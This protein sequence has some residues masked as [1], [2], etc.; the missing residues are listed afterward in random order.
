MFRSRNTRSERINRINRDNRI[1]ILNNQ[2]FV[3]IPEIIGPS[4]ISGFEKD[5]PPGFDVSFGRGDLVIEDIDDSFFD[6]QPTL[7]QR[8]GVSKV[9]TAVGLLAL[10]G[11]G[12]GAGFAIKKAFSKKK[13]ITKRDI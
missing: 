12:I 3:D 11:L 9:K 6:G 2:G 8:P 5:A 7:A 13:E 4:R 10:A 1:N